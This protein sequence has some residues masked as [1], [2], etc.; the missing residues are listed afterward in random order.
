M[1]IKHFKFQSFLK[2]NDIV[3]NNFH[4]K[5]I[6]KIAKYIFY[7]EKLKIFFD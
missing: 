2:Y 4:K 6:N 3:N 5:Q 7:Y 1:D